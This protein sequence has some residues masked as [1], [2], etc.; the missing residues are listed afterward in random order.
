[1]PPRSFW[2]RSLTSLV[3]VAHPPSSMRVFRVRNCACNSHCARNRHAA[4]PMID[5]LNLALPYFGLIFIGFAS[6][7]LKRLPEAS[8]G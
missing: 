7:N 2:V 6:G 8:R 1:M 4:Q 5:V 3:R